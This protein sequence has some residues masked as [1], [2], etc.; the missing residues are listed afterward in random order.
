MPIFSRVVQ[1]GFTLPTLQSCART[2]ENSSCQILDGK[3][4]SKHFVEQAKVLVE[5]HKILPKLAVVMVGDNPASHV[6]V[7]HKIKTFKEAGF[8]SESHLLSEHATSEL[9]IVT[10]IH[11][12]NAKADVHGILVQLPLPSH[13]N[14]DIV[15]NSI[16]PQ[17]D[18]DG[19]L[20]QNVGALACGKYNQPIACTPFG[21]M[22]LLSCYGIEVAR[23]HA[24]VVGRSNIV[25]KPMGLLLLGADATVTFAHSKTQHLQEICGDADILI[26]AAGKAQLITKEFVKPG[27]VVVDVGIH[28]NEDGKLCG[29]VH[30]NV[31]EVARALT[32]VPGGVGPMTIAML[33]IN[34]SLGVWKGTDK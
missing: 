15:L 27:A 31:T 18:V 12:L 29:D 2:F 24:V 23:K 32:P 13:I 26:A 14:Q 33:M 5:K 6:Y 19:F 17:K 21:V 20:P 30:P 8:L 10:L 1:A 3:L 22:A 34:T 16:A 25:G 28:K 11:S 7:S 4:L 9:D